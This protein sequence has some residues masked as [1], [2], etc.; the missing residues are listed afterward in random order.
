MREQ[1]DEDAS[2]ADGD[3][4]SPGSTAVLP[5]RDFLRLAAV[6]GC[7]ALAAA[8]VAAAL[9][10][11]AQVPPALA[12]RDF[13]NYWTAARLALSGNAMDLFS[14]HAD[15]FRH[16]QAAF[17]MDYPWH[18]WSYPPHYLLFVWPLGLLAYLPAMIAFLGVTFLLYLAALRSFTGRLDADILLAVLPFALFNIWAAQNGFLT[19]ALFLGALAL[20]YER[21]VLAGVLAGCLTIKPQLGVLIPILYLIEGR[22]L[23]MVSAALTTLLLVAVSAACFGVEGWIGYV[24][25]T[26]ASQSAVMAY[27]TGIFLDMM[28]APFGVMRN[29]GAE[30][31]LAFAVHAAVALP[32]LA[33]TVY[34]F[35]VVRDPVL[36]GAVLCV[37]TIAVTPYSLAYDLGGFAASVALGM[38]RSP[39]S[40]FS[41]R[42]LILLA[43]AYLPLLIVP[44]GIFGVP[45]A[46]LIVVGVLAVLLSDGAIQVKREAG[47]VI[48]RSPAASS[49]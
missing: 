19:A 28:P 33:V 20:R 42:R 12:N 40:P 5:H 18:A 35:A 43:G 2:P 1:Q 14:T 11:P 23:S 29:L 39:A 3:R 13:A 48:A 36:R 41:G 21:P 15:Y 38:T 22:W 32:V 6:L 8:F 37:A 27:A 24:Q 16:M 45:L 46:P 47:T 25:N 49:G 9:F 34:G 44:A 7:L 31:T 26:F 30:P 4:L 17:G 10:A